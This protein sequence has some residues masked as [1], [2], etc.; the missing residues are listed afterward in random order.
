MG[1]EGQMERERG[2]LED[3]KRDRMLKDGYVKV[4]ETIEK[5]MYIYLHMK[6]IAYLWCSISF[7]MKDWIE[8]KG[9]WGKSDQDKCLSVYVCR[10]LFHTL[11]NMHTK[12]G[13]NQQIVTTCKTG[14]LYEEMSNV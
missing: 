6:T 4:A 13:F 1:K 9:L 3:K 12:P 7:T 5:S 14:L 8:R 10:L 2:C 11:S